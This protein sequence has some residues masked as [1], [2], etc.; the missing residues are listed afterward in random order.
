MSLS[1]DFR[2]KS[3]EPCHIGTEKVALIA[4]QLLAISSESTWP[5]W[6]GMHAPSFYRTLNSEKG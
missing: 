5:P 4:T 2:E 3:C 6:K 1:V